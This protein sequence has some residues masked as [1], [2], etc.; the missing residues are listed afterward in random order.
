LAGCAKHYQV[1]STANSHYDLKELK[2]DSLTEVRI[3]PY[4]NKLDA[5]MS[6]TLAVCDTPLTKEGVETNLSNFVLMAVDEYVKEK[7]PAIYADYIGMINRGGLRSSL[8]KGLIKVGTIFELMPFEN[9]M[10]LL[11][12]KGSKLK[13]AIEASCKTGKLLNWNVSYTIQNNT[14]LNIMIHGKPFDINKEYTIITTDY[15]AHGG[16]ECT[17]FSDPVLSEQDGSKLRDVIINYCKI[18]SN[19]NKHIT[20]YIDGRI[21]IL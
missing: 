21:K 8:P 14:P 15:L 4:K 10:I 9:E 11:K 3:D 16:D 18:L 19:Q 6:Q 17:F 2:N 7:R 12:I 13:E 1:V 5:E 20:S